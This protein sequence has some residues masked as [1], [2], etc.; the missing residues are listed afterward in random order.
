VHLVG[1]LGQHPVQIAAGD[2]ELEIRS[3]RTTRA[4][5]T[6]PGAARLR[7]TGLPAGKGFLPKNESTTR[8]PSQVI[9]YD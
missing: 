7:G 3:L 1:A 4:A 8:Q 9:F 2:G 5:A 6:T